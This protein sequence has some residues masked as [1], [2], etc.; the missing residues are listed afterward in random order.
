MA[1]DTEATEGRHT[2]Y[3]TTD[4]VWG[5]GGLLFG[6]SGA[7]GVRQPLVRSLNE[8]VGGNG[9]DTMYAPWA[10]RE[11]LRTAYTKVL[12]AEYGGR[13]PQ[14]ADGRV[15]DEL[16]GAMLIIGRGPSGYWML[17]LDAGAQATFYEDGG[18]HAIGSGSPAAQVV[19]ALLTSYESL[20]RS[21]PHLR[22][23]AHRTVGICIETLG[24]A[25]GVGGHVEMWESDSLTD[26]RQLPQAELEIVSDGVDRWTTLERESLD[27]ALRVEGS[28]E[29]EPPGASLDELAPPEE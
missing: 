3:E 24:G 16:T 8:L 10:M 2:R 23:L 4:K 19:R 21:L 1:S 22:L 11:P 6:Y 25:Y 9:A 28:A 14:L 29:P 5:C 13:A 18:F 20:G 27:R 12:R 15:P 17:E 7:S 26:F